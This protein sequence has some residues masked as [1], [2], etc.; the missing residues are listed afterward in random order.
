VLVDTSAW[1]SF[2]AKSGYPEIKELLKSLLDEDRVATAGP[3]VLEILQGC[4]SVKERQRMEELFRALH[5]L[6]TEEHHW[7]QA[8]QTA[9]ALRRQGI[10]VSAVDALIATLAESHG[11]P[12]LH[13]DTDFKHIARHT[14]LRFP[15]SL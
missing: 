4:R 6:I 13:R 5:W 10:T 3:I 7:Y 9:F 12:L 8:G 11:C 15:E 14:G 2:F 1:I